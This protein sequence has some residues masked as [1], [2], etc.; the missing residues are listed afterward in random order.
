MIAR[1][2]QFTPDIAARFTHQ[3]VVDAYVHRPPYPAETFAIL[4]GLMVGESRAVLDVGCG[5][6]N[7]ARAMTAFAN[8][9]D[10][11]DVSAAMLTLGRGLSDGDDPCLNWLH[12]RVE[13]VALAPPYAL[14]TAGA[15]LHW[16]DLETVLPRFAD[17]LHASGVLAI[18]HLP[19]PHYP[20]GD[21]LH[22]LIRQ[23]STLQNY[24][25]FDMI[26]LLES[27]KLFTKEGEHETTPVPFTQSVEDFITFHHS[28]SSLDREVMT[29]ADI[30]AFDDALR[31]AVTPYATDGMLTF[32]VTAH[33]VWGTPRHP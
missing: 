13:D 25:P 12:G 28:M 6:G 5:P 11:V 21:T 3:S 20:W 22:A 15:S 32:S 4:A 18:A 33:V 9:V 10:A 7:I 2:A 30:A 19:T 16:M 17:A 23:Y 14:V 27:R 8:R 31:A 26:A 29:A 1:P 24:Q